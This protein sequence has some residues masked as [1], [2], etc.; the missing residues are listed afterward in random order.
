MSS[1]SGGRTGRT[2]EIP[3][4]FDAF[5]IWLLC[6]RE[7]ES[8][9]LRFY[10]LDVRDWFSGVMDSR[11]L[12]SLLD[13]L[14]DESMFKTWAIRGGDWTDDQ[15]V[16]ARL[17]NEVAL[18][19]ADGK[20]YTPDLLKSPMQIANEDAAEQYRTK[21]HRDTLRELRGE[22]APSGDNT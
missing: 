10:S 3:K 19:R 21:R 22:E 1:R 6:S 5:R 15:Y 2:G 17:V 4:A 18:S 13:G 11:R 8:D 7:I 9:L 16:A 14:P 12:F 20:G